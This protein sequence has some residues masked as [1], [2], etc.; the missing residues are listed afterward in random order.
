[1]AM[2]DMLEMAVDIVVDQR[3]WQFAPPYLF[4]IKIISVIQTIVITGIST[5]KIL[6]D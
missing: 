4:P 1:M 6:Y 5:L 2:V 3:N